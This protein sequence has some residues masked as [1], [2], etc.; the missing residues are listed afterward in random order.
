MNLQSY[1]TGPEE[2]QE[3]DTPPEAYPDAP[4]G[5]RTFVFPGGGSPRRLDAYLGEKLRAEGY[6]REKIKQAILAGQVILN[7]HPCLK[8]NTP[9]APGDE[10]TARLAP[11]A[12]VL[13]AEQGEI[14]VLW[15]DDH[16]AVLNKPAGLTV[17]PAPGRTD[18]TLAHRLLHH[19]PELAAQGG[20][21]PGIVHRLDKDTS[22]LMLVALTEKARLIMSEAFAERNV[23]K[24][25]LALAHGAFRPASGSILKPIGRH[26][27]NKTKMAVIPPAKG[28]KEAHSDY[29]TLY[30]AP[31]DVF[32]L[33]R[34]TI[35]TGRTH[36]IRVH[37]HDAGHPL[38]GDAVYPSRDRIPPAI[39]PR[40]MLHAHRLAFSH[41]VSGEALSFCAEPP[42]DFTAC[43]IT[44]ATPMQ[45]VVITGSPGG[46]KSSLT[47]LLH[48]AGMPTWSADEA[49]KRLY[50]PGGDGWHLLRSRYGD[51]FVPDAC[52]GVDKKAL[53][54]AMAASESERREVEGL[55]H[56][57]VRHSLAAFWHEWK[58]AG[59]PLAIAEIPLFLESGWRER[60]RPDGRP[61][62]QPAGREILVAVYTPFEKRRQRMAATRG[63]SD[64][65]ISAT[66]SW[67]WPE[68]K[69]VRSAD[70]VVDNSG[71]EKDLE[72]RAYSLLHVLAFLRQ[73]ERE[74]LKT[75]LCSLWK[76]RS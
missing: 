2:G 60:T 49:V 19:F 5:G 65:T 39:A 40:Q 27:S 55:I 50:K 75:R 4:A 26:P 30:T 52:A 34:V 12:A 23:H 28:G 51:R 41:P 35:H 25:Y 10:I 54:A 44:L 13:E 48:E 11:P 31:A 9:L 56:P 66:E 74:R 32:S 70:L 24:E 15:H 3:H 8:A 42:E 17:H 33:I 22:G 57:L 36:Q 6:S 72:T 71:T 14:A 64:E 53:F 67:Q 29:E 38:L 45:R 69:K 59:A 61:D 68:E 37:M 16:I 47:R 76:C 62:D 43:A 73:R 7:N 21:R 46:G 1:K 20:L 58:K 63:W 18:G